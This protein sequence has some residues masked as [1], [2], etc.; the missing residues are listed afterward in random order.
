MDYSPLTREEMINVIEGKDNARRIPMIYQ[1]WTYDGIWGDDNNR[2]KQLKERYPYDISYI[3]YRYPEVLE[4]PEDDPCYRWVNNVDEKDFEGVAQDARVVISDYETQLDEMLANFPSPFYKGLFPEN[5]PEDGRYRLGHWWHFMFERLWSIRGMTEL[6]MDLICDQQSVHRIL[7]KLTDF[8]C[9]WVERGRNECNLDGIFVSDDLG[10]QTGSFFSTDILR[11]IFQPYY[12]K[13]IDKVH[14]LG[15][16]FWLHT[17]G[18]IENFLPDLIEMGVDVIHPIQKYTMDE[19]R[20]AQKY[21]DKI[22]V[23]AGFDVQRLIPYGTPE[24]CRQEVRFLIDTF[25]KQEGKL[26]LTFGNGLTVDTPIESIEA[27]MD[28]ALQYGTM[29]CST[30][31]ESRRPNGENTY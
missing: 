5:P 1:F 10:T 17:C 13:V 16:H 6:L 14:S 27:V 29:K 28:E 20:I 31:L 19:K 21:G 9:V 26:M 11:E 15:M 8:Y 12:K 7:E 25:W 23:L 24:E 22:C 30:A 3:K 18:N 2:V 4:A